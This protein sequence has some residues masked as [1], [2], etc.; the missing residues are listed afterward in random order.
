[1]IYRVQRGG[2]YG[3]SILEGS[4]QPVKPAGK[5]G[6]TPLLPPTREHPHSEAASITG[7]CVYRGKRLPDLAGGYIYGDYETGKIW[8]LRHDGSRVT[9]SRE[10][11]DTRL[12]VVSFGEDRDGGRYLADYGGRRD[13]PG[14][15]ARSQSP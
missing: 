6:P 8:E 14:A 3:W 9:R 11:V 5:R 12:K 7:G 13:L 4:H 2:N 1:M 15:R 10:L